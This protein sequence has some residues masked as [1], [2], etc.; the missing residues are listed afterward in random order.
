M[1]LDDDPEDPDYDSGGDQESDDS[2]ADNDLEQTTANEAIRVRRDPADF[3]RITKALLNPEIEGLAA[4]HDRRTRHVDQRLEESDERRRRKLL[5]R[6][7]RNEKNARRAKKA[8]A[9]ANAS[10]PAPGS[11]ATR[12]SPSPSPPAAYD[13]DIYDD[14]WENLNDADSVKSMETN[15]ETELVY[16]WSEWDRG[17]T[18][19]WDEF[20]R[21]SSPESAYSEMPSDYAASCTSTDLKAEPE[22][23]EEFREEIARMKRPKSIVSRNR[24]A[25]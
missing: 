22:P 15:P 6:A 23:T 1:D 16:S 12:Q 11:S 24:P 20:N 4:D 2:G 13:P 21:G 8:A 19:D 14:S 3:A 10:N 17:F 18:G 7:A 25:H 5:A 9:A